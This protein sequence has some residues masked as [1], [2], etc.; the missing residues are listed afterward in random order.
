M[1]RN[2]LLASTVVCI[3]FTPS[4]SGGRAIAFCIVSADE[5]RTGR[6]ACAV[7]SV[8][9][10]RGAVFSIVF[11]LCPSSAGSF[12][13]VMQSNGPVPCCLWHEH[14]WISLGSFTQ[15]HKTTEKWCILI[16]SPLKPLEG[17][18]A[19]CHRASNIIDWTS[20]F[21]FAHVYDYS[22]HDNTFFLCVR[23]CDYTKR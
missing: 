23:V 5:T 1:G 3:P 20:P 13:A 10:C 7:W 9:S 16:Y 19:P 8:C 14:H 11:S 2:Q 6:G 12:H 15:Q 18:T 17:I 22:K 4:S 21:L